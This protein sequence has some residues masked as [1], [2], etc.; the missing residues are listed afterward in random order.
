V[1]VVPPPSFVSTST[2]P[3][4]LRRALHDGEPS[5]YRRRVRSRRARTTVLEIGRDAGPLSLTRSVTGFSIPAPPAGHSPREPVRTFTAR[6]SRGLHGIEHEV[7]HDA[8]QQSSSPSIG[9]GHP[10]A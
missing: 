10:R 1:N 7:R 8:M 2:R 5:P 6:A 9:V 4:A 3:H